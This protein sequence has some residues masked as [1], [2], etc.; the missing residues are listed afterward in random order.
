MRT[1]PIPSRRNDVDT[2]RAVVVLLLVP[3]HTARLFDAEVWHI[4]HV[5]EPIWAADFLVRFL[6][7]AQMPLLFLLAG[8]SAA[9]ALERRGGPAFLRERFARLIVPLLIGMVILV[10]PQVWVE[11]VSPDAPLRMSPID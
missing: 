7:V 9:W 6:N 4:K 2:L 8:M 5:S 11:R 10:A 3:F 1:P